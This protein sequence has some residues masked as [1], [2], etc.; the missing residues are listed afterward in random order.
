MNI[1][2]F[3]VSKRPIAWTAMISVLAWGVYAYLMMPQRQDPIIPVV[4]GVILTPYPGAEAEKV[5]QEV[6]RKI[7]RKVA[8]NPA[9]EHV[10]S[11]SRPG[12]SIVYV[13]LFE[14]ERNAELVWQDIRG[15]LGE[16]PDLPQAAGQP[17]QSF[18]NK[19][20][21]D[22]VAIM[23]T[24]SSPP[25]TDLEVE[26]RARSIR[27][28]IRAHRQ[29]TRATPPGDRWSGVLIYPSMVSRSH[30]VRMGRLLAQHLIESGTAREAAIV[31]APSA[32]IL[33]VTL[34]P[35]K[36]RGDLQ[37][38]TD[39][40]ERETAGASEYQPDVWQ[41]F[42]IQDLDGL[43]NELRRSARDKYTYRELK[44]FADRIR[45]RLKQSP[46]VAQ[47]DLVGVQDERVWLSY[48][49][50]RL[51]QFGITPLSLVDRI[52][53][54]NINIPG[55]QVELP[56]QN[57]VVRPTGEYTSAA[58][59]GNTVLAL[60]DKGYPLYLRDLVEVTRGYEDPADVLNF[61][62]IKVAPGRASGEDGGSAGLASHAEHE[63]PEEYEL[64]TGRAITISVR[65]VKGT[66]IHDYDRDVTAAI[67]EMKLQL[68]QDLRL[69][70]TSN[71][72]AE[73]H[74][75]ISSFNRCLIEAIVIVVLVSMLFMEWRSA[76]LVAVC[77]PIT[78]AMT[79]GMARFIGIDL[80][81]VSIAALIIAL[82]ML[83]D[84]PVVA[85][86]AIN[87]ELAH[88]RPRSVAAWLGPRRL[89]RA[90]FYAT[91]T[92]IVAFLP[93]LLVKG[94]TGDFIYSLPIV[95]S[96]SLVAAM[97]VAWVFAPLLGFYVL[98][99]QKGFEA[100]DGRPA[101][102]FPRLYKAF[103]E[104]CI[105][106]RLV[107]AAVAVLIIVAGAL[108]VRSIGSSFFPKDL[109]DVFVVNLDLPE[110]SP[111][112][113]AREVALDAV[114][115]IDALE[116]RNVR[117]YTT[118]V[119]AGGPRFWLSIEP[120]QRADNYA[121]ILVH[122][123]DKHETASVVDRLK[124]ELATRI[125]DARVRTQM[126]ETGPP[127]GIP[128]QLRVYGADAETLRDLA[129]QVKARLR[130][131]PGTIDVH[132]DWG[133]PVFQMTLKIDSDRAAMSGLTHQDVAYAV[134]TGLSGLSVS[135]VRERDRLIDIM[136]RLRPLE[137]SRL[138]DLYSLNV[139]NAAT[140][141]GMPLRQLAAFERELV[142]PKIRRRDHERCITVRCDTVPGVLPSEVVA[143][144]QRLLPARS[145]AGGSGGNTIAFPAGYRWE[146][147]GEKFEQ[148]KGF[149]SLTIALVVSFVAIYLA[150]VLQFNSATQPILI[151]AAVPFGV[152]GGLT[153]LLIFGS[154]F[155]FMAF[156]GVASLAGLI[157]SH[158]IVLFDFID[159]MRHKG[160]PL[161]KAVV[162]AGLAR[163]RPVVV[164]VLA[165]VG[166]LIPLAHSGGPLWEPM[167]YV[168]I[169]GMLVATVVTLVLVPVLYVIF[170]EDLHLV[171]WEMESVAQP[172]NGLGVAG[173]QPARPS[174]TA[175]LH[176]PS[177]GA[178]AAAALAM[179]DSTPLGAGPKEDQP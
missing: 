69:E 3:F 95:V 58:E 104:G 60:S 139:V 94:K 101:T 93:L 128:V 166:G 83:V 121:Q 24:I 30:V 130:S 114:H 110:G 177:S 90:V 54:R 52:R 5:E 76:L 4:T 81:Q 66:H 147:G 19:D 2:Q 158:V 107:S 39:R 43:E 47:I 65:Q 28:T 87:R 113:H 91:F 68:P 20:F 143:D 23:L 77:I 161:R 16:I 64:Q 36:T 15:K 155:G 102:G 165:C 148:D 57:V 6:T 32:R 53:Q 27:E 41:P 171:R 7:E 137:R 132:D 174:G 111:I 156:L 71:E 40:W 159:E 34:D 14:T 98:K 35:G 44:H 85:A 144:L 86:D 122:T 42:W 73:V 136:L 80:Q 103:V 22:S 120:E 109:H 79:L 134:G 150:L 125:S 88:G 18:L 8:E 142:T 178:E 123:A 163:L 118:F 167:C 56:D 175:P 135:N 67:E 92:N 62:T 72:P 51:N 179:S 145:P 127:I 49:G 1:S 117:S 10:K 106:H 124:R 176:A 131:I 146:F 126:L 48:S 11:I 140:G 149:K 173:A 105:A 45:D 26:L 25:V 154:T 116:G 12:I 100:S 119:G 50:Q 115:Q 129:S 138:D 59:I 133:D 164:T 169:V 17:T 78:V 9:V 21:G 97:L 84:A 37:K 99:G 89:A 170:V 112:R 82:G 55:G 153:G 75:K 13:E 38:A 70:R 63:V 61:R 151:Y 152:V 172:E 33:D 162:D 46:Y 29:Q 160:E 74:H 168:Q 96:L 141:V 108:L 31:E 157:I